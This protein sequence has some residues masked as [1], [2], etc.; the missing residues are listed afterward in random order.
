MNTIS[1]AINAEILKSFA[2]YDE[3]QVQALFEQESASFDKKIVVLD[4][5]PT[6]VQT[7]NSIFVYTRWNQAVF[8]EAFSSDNRLFFILTNSRALSV[9]ETT[10]L[11]AAIAENIDNAA[12][13][14]GV[15]YVVISR[16]DSILRGHYPLETRV[17]KE[18]IEVNSKER[19]DGEIICPFF[20]EGGRFTINNTH[21]V[22]YGDELVPA[23]ETEFAKDKTFGY[24]SSDLTD[25][26]AEKSNNVFPADGVVTVSLEELR[27]LQIEAVI[28][29]LCSLQ[30]FA[31]LV[32]NAIDY[33]D[34]RV[35]MTAFF[36]AVST[37][38]RFMFRTAAAIPKIMG[39][40][41]DKDL[42]QRDQ[43][44]DE[45]NAHGGLVVIGSYTQKT[46]DQFNALKELNAL[47]EIG[48]DSEL[49]DDPQG[50]AVEIERVVGEAE[51]AM[52]D[53]KTAVIYT[54]RT[55]LAKTFKDK[56]EA[57]RASVMISDGV[58]E[59]VSRIEIKP[60]FIVAKGGITSSEIGTKALRVEKALVLGQ[61]APGIPVWLTDSMSK[62]PNMPYIIFPG[63]VGGAETLK[64]I[65]EK[66]Q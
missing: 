34:I 63:N 44:I 21:Y 1:N 64:E 3:A 2:D 43:L 15:D 46:T 9:E 48:F 6:G 51:R 38:K 22:Q 62:F 57:L 5:D 45:N 47:H 20:Q 58:T 29:K 49:Y 37:G 66:I 65:V 10:S 19:F 30:G 52:A 11:H 59:I 36:K 16:S 27:G 28:G 61:V 53:G 7:V 23:G 35:F 54:K 56:E 40:V 13:E 18:N 31:K 32:V 12:K 50:F 55:P 4:D 42:L 17:L 25:W 60:R 14:V 8:E 39:D 33:N 26:V 41:Q 24:S